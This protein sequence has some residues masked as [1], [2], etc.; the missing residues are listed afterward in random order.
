MAL[1]TLTILNQYPSCRIVR[2]TKK[3]CKIAYSFE[4]PPE[5]PGGIL[6]YV[7]VRTL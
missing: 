3:T 6:K 4:T 7:A 5:R 1:N 2:M